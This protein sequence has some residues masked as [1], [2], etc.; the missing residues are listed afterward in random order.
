MPQKK[1]RVVDQGTLPVMGPLI[2]QSGADDVVIVVN[3]H[4]WHCVRCGTRGQLNI[5][6][7]RHLRHHFRIP[8][9]VKQAGACETKKQQVLSENAIIT[10]RRQASVAGVC[11]TPSGHMVHSLSRFVTDS[12]DGSPQDGRG[13]P[14]HDHHYSSQVSPIAPEKEKEHN[15]G[16]TVA[17]SQPSTAVDGTSWSGASL[18]DTIQRYIQERSATAKKLVPDTTQHTQ[19]PDCELRSAPYCSEESYSHCFLMDRV[20]AGSTE[21]RC[22]LNGDSMETNTVSYE[23]ADVNRHTSHTDLI[24]SATLMLSSACV[25]DFQIP[26]GN[27]ASPAGAYDSGRTDC[28]DCTATVTNEIQPAL[29]NKT[30]A[31]EGSFILSHGHTLGAFMTAG[32]TESQKSALVDSVFCQTPETPDPAK[33]SDAHCPVTEMNIHSSHQSLQISGGSKP[34]A[35]DFPVTD[36]NSVEES[37]SLDADAHQANEFLPVTL[38]R[39]SVVEVEVHQGQLVSVYPVTVMGDGQLVLDTLPQHLHESVVQHFMDSS[40]NV[41][42]VNRGVSETSNGSCQPSNVPVAFIASSSKPSLI[43]KHI[44]VEPR[45]N[46]VKEDVKS[47]YMRIVKPRKMVNML[48]IFNT[49]SGSSE[50]SQTEVHGLS[51][52]THQK[53]LKAANE[54]SGSHSHDFTDTLPSVSLTKN[55]QPVSQQANVCMVVVP[56]TEGNQGDEQQLSSEAHSAVVALMSSSCPSSPRCQVCEEVFLSVTNLA[57]HELEMSVFDIV[58]CKNCLKK[59]HG[60]LRLN[61]HVFEQHLSENQAFCFMCGEVCNSAQDLKMHVISHRTPSIRHSEGSRGT[62]NRKWYYCNLCKKRLVNRSSVIKMHNFH[63]HTPNRR[64]RCTFCG[65]SFVRWCQLDQHK[66]DKHYGMR[67][68]C[69][70]CHTPCFSQGGLSRHMRA[71]RLD[72]SEAAGNKEDSN[73]LCPE[74]GKMFV[75]AANLRTHIQK[76]KRKK[77]HKRRYACELCEQQYAAR[78]SLERHVAVKHAGVVEYKYRCAPCNKQFYRSVQLRDHNATHHLGVRPYACNYCHQ[79]FV[80]NPTRLRHIR[81]EHTKM[82]KYFCSVCG[83]GFFYQDRLLYHMTKH[84]CVR[85]FSCSHCGKTFSIKQG[86]TKHMKLHAQ[87]LHVCDRCGHS[88]ARSD[89]FKNHCKSCKLSILG[90]K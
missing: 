60:V 37:P 69:P 40:Q 47:A 78:S 16:I 11:T 32:G 45:T 68:E 33:G 17:S 18:L 65:E 44:R 10:E 84:T 34:E 35:F 51:G 26:D 48:E 85:P 13:F 87:H 12:S 21:K 49:L 57:A 42:D 7:N 56:Q 20:Y 66:Q 89:H 61:V 50:I 25:T 30:D 43:Q 76:H 82:K 46:P 9:A 22:E 23:L 14:L 88:F 58:E 83:E 62:A 29:G 38:N 90:Q 67:H 53:G 79:R 80:C 63:K 54:A 15:G 24:S 72:G 55:C 74:C 86:L 3:S 39:D 77:A 8:S 52:G 28:A 71:H 41:A 5:S 27:G 4:G 70:I 19:T 59:F 81:R 73:C 1:E 31:A 64:F 6:V 2:V 36:S 75:N